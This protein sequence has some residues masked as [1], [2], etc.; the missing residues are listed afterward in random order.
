MT[1]FRALC[2]ELVNELVAWQ[3]ADDLFSDGGTIRGDADH[4]LAPRARA[5]LDAP[6]GEEPSD[7][8]PYEDAPV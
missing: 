1:N 8:A 3:Q 6:E 4:D 2:A 5:A 7:E